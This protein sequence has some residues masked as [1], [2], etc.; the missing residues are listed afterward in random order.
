MS[1]L[2]CQALLLPVAVSLHCRHLVAQY[3]REVISA[4]IGHSTSPSRPGHLPPAPRPGSRA[5][6]SSLEEPAA[7]P[8]QLYDCS[9]ESPRP[10]SKPISDYGRPGGGPPYRT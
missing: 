8:P 1:I 5:A 6:G 4:S 3:T 2:T 10:H 9:T 7:L